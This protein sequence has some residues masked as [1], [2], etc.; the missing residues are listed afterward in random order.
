M[1]GQNQKQDLGEYKFPAGYSEDILH[2]ITL[3]FLA[4]AVT[5]QENLAKIAAAKPADSVG[6]N[7]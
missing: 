1:T 7:A 3:A 6:M 5:R 2:P 4:D